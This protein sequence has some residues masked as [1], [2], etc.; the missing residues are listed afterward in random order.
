MTDREA[1]IAYAKG[2][3]RSFAVRLAAYILSVALI[4][5]LTVLFFDNVT[6]MFLL[7]A[8]LILLIVLFAR[9]YPK[10]KAPLT[11]KVVDGEIVKLHRE[12]LEVNVMKTHNYSMVRK[13]YSNYYRD[14]FTMT[15]FVK[16]GNGEVIP[17]VASGLS[18]GICDYYSVGDRVLLISGILLP[19]PTNIKDTRGIC[20]LCGE[21]EPADDHDCIAKKR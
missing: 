19:V 2:R 16:A 18:S 14:S 3:R 5:A 6:I 9:T 12:K 17:H 10:I 7:A 1:L 20:P 8:A 4:I 13:P 11:I 15:V 21:L